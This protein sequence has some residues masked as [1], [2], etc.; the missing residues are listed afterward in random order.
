MRQI[1]LP[2]AAKN[3]RAASSGVYDFCN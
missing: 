1:G 2:F 3:A